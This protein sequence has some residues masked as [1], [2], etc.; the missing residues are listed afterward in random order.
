MTNYQMSYYK[1][2]DG[3]K[4]NDELKEETADTFFP[5]ELYEML[6][7]T[8]NCKTIYKRFIRSSLNPNFHFE[9]RENPGINFWVESEFR[10]IEQFNEF[11]N[12]FN[13]EQLARFKSFENSFLFLSVKIQRER[14]YYFIP[15]NH[16]KTDELHFSF[17]NTYSV[18]IDFPVKPEMIKRYLRK[19]L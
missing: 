19:F 10:E 11:I 7:Q 6:H 2:M 5:D 8:H 9:I 17:L 3:V 1:V 15:F 4:S 12:V 18:S 14:Y 13:S 16:I